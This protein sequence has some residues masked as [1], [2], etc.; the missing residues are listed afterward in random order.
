MTEWWDVLDIQLKVFYIIGITSTLVL[1]VQV[2]LMAV[3]IGDGDAG[4]GDAVDVGGDA[5]MEN[6]GDLHVLSIRTVVA[7]FAG[8]GWTGVICL[9]EGYS[10]GTAL[11]ISVLVGGVFM[12]TVFYLMRFLYSLRDSGNIHYRNAVGKVGSVYVPIPPNQTGA[13]QVEVMIQGRVRFVQA[14]TRSDRKLPSNSRV[15]VV[16]ILDPRTLLVEPLEVP[17]TEAQEN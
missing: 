14:F 3:G 1:L 10:L 11:G 6:P 16:E 17:P 12:M 9:K 5:S 2:V 8:F 13:G 15:K 4:A 7:F